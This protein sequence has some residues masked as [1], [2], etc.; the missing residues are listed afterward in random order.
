M[1]ENPSLFAALIDEMRE[2]SLLS[3]TETIGSILDKGLNGQLISG[4]IGEG[5]LGEDEVRVGE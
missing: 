2:T 3:L 5:N 1:D 4:Q